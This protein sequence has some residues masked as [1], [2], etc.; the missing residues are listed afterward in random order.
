[1]LVGTRPKRRGRLDPTSFPLSHPHKIFSSWP[2]FL[3]YIVFKCSR[4]SFAVLSKQKL[5]NLE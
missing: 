5:K 4:K 3:L 2:F 1:M